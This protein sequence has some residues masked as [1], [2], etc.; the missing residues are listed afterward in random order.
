MPKLRL[1]LQSALFVAGAA[2][3]LPLA[4]APAYAKSTKSIERKE[5]DLAAAGFLVK[6]ANTPERAAMLARLPANTFVQHVNGDTV[7]YVYADPKACNC[8]YVGTQEAYGQYR[9]T[10]QAKDLVDQQRW[11]AQDYADARW[12]WGAWG[13]WGPRW[14]F[15]RRGW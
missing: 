1:M 11:A 13:A 10:M 14:G 12:N 2:A 7:T 8:L 3:L 6:P 9:R 5:G 4:A 15:G